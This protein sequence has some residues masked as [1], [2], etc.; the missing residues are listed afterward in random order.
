MYDGE[1]L[2]I[3]AKDAR[4]RRLSFARNR[5]AQAILTLGLYDRAAINLFAA[6]RTSIPL[7]VVY[8]N[9]TIVFAGH[10][11]PMS[12]G[13][14]VDSDSFVN[15]VFKDAFAIYDYRLTA[16]PDEVYSAEDQGI[17]ARTLI[18]TADSYYGPTYLNT[19]NGTIEATRPRDRT[20]NSKPV[21]EAVI[22]LTEVIGGIDWYGTYT[23]P[24]THVGRTMTF[25]VAARYGTD[26]PGARFEFGEGTLENCRSYTFTTGLPV[27]VVRA[28]GA[29]GV[30][31]EV[32]DDDSW[33]RFG[34]YVVAL[35]ASDVSE[36]ATLDDLA[37]DAIRTDPVMV[38]G[39]VGDPARCPTPW[40]DFWIGDTL[41]C[42]VD[43][44]AVQYQG[45]PRVQTIDVGLDEE[46][47]IADLVV[48]ID[49]AASG[50]YLS[51][52]ASTRRYVQQQRDLL[53]RLSALER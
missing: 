51:P 50:A 24:V 14:A 23:N 27:N 2:P 41:R 39:L 19:S 10:W 49:P 8:R 12:G 52:A 7:L 22:E 28:I 42:N 20:Y 31:R 9:G 43:D 11:W 47:N 13:N 34:P 45:E 40:D 16:L 32:Q 38:T 44:G 18:E 15:L 1:G 37:R 36:T 48:G 3:P 26:R 17:I 30:P 33:D 35:A 53:R 29:G 46:D 21:S 25:N 4:G 5:A 6:L